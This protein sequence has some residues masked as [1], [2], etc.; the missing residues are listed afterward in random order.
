[1][2]PMCDACKFTLISLL[3][4]RFGRLHPPGGLI[5]FSRAGNSAQ[6]GNQFIPPGLPAQIP[7]LRSIAAYHVPSNTSTTVI[8]K[9][10]RSATSL[11]LAHLAQTFESSNGTEHLEGRTG[12]PRRPRRWS[13]GQSLQTAEEPR[14]MVN[15]RSWFSRAH[16]NQASGIGLGTL[17]RVVDGVC[18]QVPVPS[19]VPVSVPS[20][21]RRPCSSGAGLEAPL[22]RFPSD[23]ARPQLKLRE[24]RTPLLL[25]EPGL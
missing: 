12:I 15:I 14:D 17:I 9:P 18:F 4:G 5:M 11:Q 25:Q 7:A 10:S 16:T 24:F 22:D 3:R 23:H 13:P 2:T 20:A 8:P 1:M 6:E 21:A 19:L